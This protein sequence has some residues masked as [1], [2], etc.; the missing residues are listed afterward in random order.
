MWW[1]PQAVLCGR[2]ATEIQNST[3][4]CAGCIW[5]IQ[6]LQA[7][8]KPSQRRWWPCDSFLCLLWNGCVDQV[9]LAGYQYNPSYLWHSHFSCLDCW[10]TYGNLWL[11]YHNNQYAHGHTQQI[12]VVLGTWLLMTTVSP[13]VLKQLQIVIVVQ[14]TFEVGWG[15]LYLLAFVCR[16]NCKCW[17]LFWSQLCSWATHSHMAKVAEGFFHCKPNS[18]LLPL[19]WDAGVAPMLWERRQ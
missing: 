1:A 8:Q 19:K 18:V 5:A 4:S 16:M 15:C 11:L 6:L 3:E 17:E 9:H 2:P 14:L 10:P 13:K 12:A 7:L